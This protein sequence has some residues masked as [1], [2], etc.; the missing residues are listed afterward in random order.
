[1]RFLHIVGNR[2]HF[3]KLAFLVRATTGRDI[4]NVV[5]HSGQ[6]YDYQMSECF[7]RD[8]E[9]RPPAYNLGVG[10][11]SHGVQTGLILSRLD[12]ILSAER[13]DAIVV[14]GDT[15]TTLAGALA[16]CKTQV[17]LAHVEAGLREFT[18]RPEE[19][20]RKLTDC[21]SQLLFCPT[22]RAAENLREEGVAEERIFMTGDITYDAFL[23]AARSLDSEGMRGKNME[24]YALV[25]LHRA[26]T[27][28]DRDALTE[29]GE[30]L[31][32]L[33]EQ[34][35]FPVHPRTCKMLAQYGLLQAL[36][37]SPFVKLLPPQGYY[38][39][40]RLLLDSDLVI[41]DSGGVIKEAFYARKPCVTL[42][43][44]NEYPEIY[45]TGLNVL[46]GKSK[47]SILSAAVAVRQVDASAILPSAVFGDGHAA[48]RM[49]DTLMS[50]AR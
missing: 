42:D 4:E 12:P 18:N 22:P 41:T 37:D 32:A 25:T 28:D 34:V 45:D 11:G 46:A 24:H 26:E 30:T 16:A 39:F 29:I 50:T 49:V 36:E 1:M 6:H 47:D 21:C 44:T 8:F 15:N 17:P 19:V 35:V 40:L 38:D 23:A 48:E 5:V 7:M 2:P 43:F 20:N 31:L 10:S 14:Y 9:L 3:V 33:G 27:V 13:P